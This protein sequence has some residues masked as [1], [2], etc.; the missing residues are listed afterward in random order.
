MPN[1]IQKELDKVESTLDIDNYT[2]VNEDGEHLNYW[3]V[4]EVLYCKVDELVQDWDESE[5]MDL[6]LSFQGI[7]ESLQKYE[8]KSIE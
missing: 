4:T 2:N 8:A 5:A 1:S 7:I 6:L 3:K